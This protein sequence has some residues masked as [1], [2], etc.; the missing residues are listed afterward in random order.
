MRKPTTILALLLI[1]AI[2]LA[3]SAQTPPQRHHITSCL[4]GLLFIDGCLGAPNGTIQSPNL[5]NSYGANRPPWNVAGVDYHVGI[6]VGTTLADPTTAGLPTGC[7]FSG[8]TVTCAS[9]T[10]TVNAMDFSLH[11]GTTLSITGGTVTVSNSK[12]IVGTNQGS[13]GR[14]ISVTGSGS[15]TFLNNEIDGA[16]IAVT[17]QVGQTINISNT[18]TIAFK[19][20]YMHNSGGDMIDFNSTSSAHVEVFRYNYLRDIGYAVAHSDTL[21]W[22]GTKISSADIGFNTIYQPLSGLSGEGL[23]NANSECSGAAQADIVI[24]NNTLLS[25]TQDN[26]GIGTVVTQ[27]AGT[28]TGARVA[29]FDNYLD[30][31]G[32]NNFTASPWFALG[33]TGTAYAG[34]ALPNPAILHGLVNL[35]TGSTI[36][37]PTLS[38]PT[39]VSPHYFVYPDSAGYSPSL[40]D[41]YNLSASPSSGTIT[42]GTIAISLNMAVPWTVT[43]GPPTLAL[44]TSPARTASYTSGSGSNTLVFTYTIAS[45]DTATNLAVTSLA[46]NGGTVEDAFGNTAVL[47]GTAATFSGLTISGAAAPGNTVLP[48]I[49]GTATSGSTLTTTN[50]TW[51]NSPTSFTYQWTRAD[52][53]TSISG[54]TASTYVLTATDVGHTITVSVTAT[55]ASGSTPVTST[56]L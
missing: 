30:P 38:V 10:P 1:F 17:A 28:A 45:G 47:T 8:T 51:T 6:P 21:Q 40:N 16:N 11:N 24:H 27:D 37:V 20:N 3:F 12:F 32:V 23:I 31:T 41:I 55:N 54:A 5:L 26:W 18:G 49:S 53:S 15:A 43:G 4:K 42:S 19:Y 29:I 52:T 48:V 9:G 34:A 46:L 50:G 56:C 25:I 13:T 39:A 22:C 7:T 36:P 14:I 33:D 35:V 2:P 44:S